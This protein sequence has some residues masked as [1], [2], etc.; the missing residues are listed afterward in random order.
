MKK[1]SLP[2]LIA[3]VFILNGLIYL[4][5]VMTIEDVDLIFGECARNSGRTAAAINLSILLMVG[6]VGLKSIYSEESKKNLFRTL[7]T[8]F[9][10]N[11][12]IHFYF[13]TQ[14]FKSYELE[15]NISEQLQ[16][17]ITFLFIL[18]T[19]VVLWSLQD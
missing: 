6:H 5:A 3:F 2:L 18:I 15:L 10:I 7:I 13:V 19:P 11:H 14:N 1:F 4:R 17:F 9:A 12:L 8:I 16:G